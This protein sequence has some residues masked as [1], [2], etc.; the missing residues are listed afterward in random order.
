MSH[1]TA[2]P[3]QRA[4]AASLSFRSSTE[5]D[6]ALVALQTELREVQARLVTLEQERRDLARELAGLRAREGG[7][8]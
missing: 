4:L 7:G 6:A 2:T 3:E 5:R 8:K 1:S